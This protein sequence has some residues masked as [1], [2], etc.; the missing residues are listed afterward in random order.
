V[1]ANTTAKIAK[2][3]AATHPKIVIISVGAEPAA[4]SR[5]L[6]LSGRKQP[7]GIV[8]PDERHTVSSGPMADTL[9]FDLHRSAGLVLTDAPHA[10]L[11]HG[12]LPTAQDEIV[13]TGAA[14]DV[15]PNDA[16][17]FQLVDDLH[18]ATLP[19]QGR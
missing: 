14:A 7:I 15:E 2:Q 8:H 10:L 1:H 9:I 6:P 4:A 18:H 5:F 12:M 16:A 19:N 13:V 17:V 3:I 11:V